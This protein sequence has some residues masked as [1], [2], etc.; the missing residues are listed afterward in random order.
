MSRVQF[1][2]STTTLLLFA[3]QKIFKQY[4][5]IA[6]LNFKPTCSSLL[7]YSSQFTVKNKCVNVI[8]LLGNDKSTPII[9]K[10][11]SNLLPKSQIQI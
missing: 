8:T 2:T 11:Y 10:G 3:E 5:Y 4:L 6:F 7:L 1:L 9:P